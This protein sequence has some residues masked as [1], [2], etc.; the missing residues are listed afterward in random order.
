MQDGAKAMEDGK[1]L[2]TIKES[3]GVW[4]TVCKES[5]IW[6]WGGPTLH[7]KP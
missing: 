1:S 5:I 4:E 2:G 7:G 3:S 6:N